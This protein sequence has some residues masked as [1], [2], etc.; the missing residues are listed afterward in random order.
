MQGVRY[1]FYEVHAKSD[2]VN[3]T[4]YATR[5]LTHAIAVGTAGNIAAVMADD[6]VVVVPVAAGINEIALKRINSTNTTAITFAA[7]YQV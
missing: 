7:L 3:V 6:T 4:A 5:G 1:N 2:T